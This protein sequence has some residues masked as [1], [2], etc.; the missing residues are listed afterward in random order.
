MLGWDRY[1]FNKKRVGTRYTE[2]MFFHLVGSTGHVVHSAVPRVENVDELFLMLRCALCGFHEK[3]VETRYA[4][5]VF[6]HP[7]GFAGHVVHSGAS[8]P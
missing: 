4:E 6:L 5:L 7:M 2:L 1:G 8:G 3:C